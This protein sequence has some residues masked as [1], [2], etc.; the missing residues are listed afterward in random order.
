VG[1]GKDGLRGGKKSKQLNE[2]YE[3]EKGQNGI[4]LQTGRFNSIS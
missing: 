3:L 4:D 1:K 2:G